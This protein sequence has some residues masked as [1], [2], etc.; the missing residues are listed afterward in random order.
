M[1]INEKKSD[2]LNV[3]V[4]IEKKEEK[5]ETAQFEDIN[6]PHLIQNILHLTT[7]S[8]QTGLE[9]ENNTVKSLFSFNESILPILDNDDIDID[10]FN[11]YL[12]TQIIKNNLYNVNFETVNKKN[13][14]LNKKIK[15][16]NELKQKV[17]E[18]NNKLIAKKMEENDN[19]KNLEEKK[20]EELSNKLF[21]SQHPLISLFEET[22]NIKQIKEELYKE[23][24]NKKKDNTN[25]K[26]AS[27]LQNSNLAN[28]Q[29]IILNQ[30]ENDDEDEGEF[31]QDNV[32]EEQEEDIAGNYS[33]DSYN[34]NMSVGINENIDYLHDNNAIEN[35]NNNNN[36]ENINNNNENL[37][38]NN[39]ANNENQNN[40]NENV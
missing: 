29:Q 10:S 38:G 35:N 24:Q 5:L 27:F 18:Y 28:L 31:Y 25:Y 32:E 20:K 39:N 19:N 21:L 26:Y 37:I 8:F 17:S 15:Q 30:N 40:N 7:H 1:D 23:Y 2:T 4:K 34:S 16:Y 12:Q 3:D 33:D 13:S 14:F 22:I 36:A 9:L 11:P 6:S